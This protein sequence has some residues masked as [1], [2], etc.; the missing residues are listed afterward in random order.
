MSS[1]RIVTRLQDILANITAIDK[2]VSGLSLAQFS[3]QQIVI[4][5]CERCLQRI[6]EAVI[7]IGAERMGEIAPD[8]PFHVIRGMG[9]ALRHAYDDID[10]AIVYHYDRA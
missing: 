1:D 2:Y 7:K 10:G 3:A 9:N 6:T 5:A 8:I 4:D